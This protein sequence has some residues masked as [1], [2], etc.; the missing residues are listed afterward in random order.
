MRTLQRKRTS[1]KLP[2]ARVYGPAHWCRGGCQLI[3]G[4][5]ALQ[6][7]LAGATLAFKFDGKDRANGCAGG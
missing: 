4:W 3:A 6:A 7:L 2:I 1:T 5:A